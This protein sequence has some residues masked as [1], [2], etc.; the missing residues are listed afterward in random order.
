L[1]FVQRIFINIIGHCRHPMSL[2]AETNIYTPRQRY[3]LLITTL[4]ILGGL[5][6]YGMLGYLTAFLGAGI[7]YV[8]LRPWFTALVHKRGWN[9]T[10]VTVLLLLFAVVVLIIPFFALTSLL[11]DKVRIVA[12]NTDQILATVQ[13][14]ER[15]LGVQVTQQAQVRQLLQQGAARVSQWIPT[16]ASSVLN[17]IVIVGLMLFTMYYLFMQEEAFLAG[18]RR[19]LPFREKTLDELSESLRNNVNANV[20]GQGVVC[21]VQ[22]LLTGITLWIFGVPS[23]I[24]W[25]VIAFFMAFIPVLGTPLVWGPAAIYQFAQGH[26]GQGIGILIVGVV[27][28]VNSDNVLRIWMA[29]YM[30]DIHPWV[31][32]V[33]LTLGVDIFGIVGLVIGPLLLSYFIVLMQVFA[34]ENRV[35]LHLLPES[36]TGKAEEIVDKSNQVRQEAEEIRRTQ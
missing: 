34:R 27:L 35:L 3:L 19:Y 26:N 10:L 1:F 6:F 13:G 11:I 31:T 29:K 4:V 16:L 24:F 23:P 9:R 15:K 36:P 22:A 5:A 21:L 18:L 20:L 17:V 33:G 28:I 25:T 32:L 2:P 7:L 12:Q 14:I 30:G 8:V